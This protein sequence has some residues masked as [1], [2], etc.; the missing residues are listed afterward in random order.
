MHKAR[1]EGAAEY[2]TDLTFHGDGVTFCVRT[3]AKRT[4]ELPYV[5]IQIAKENLAIGRRREPNTTKHAE[6][7]PLYLCSH[8]PERVTRVTEDL[9]FFTEI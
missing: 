3:H 7:E 9:C 4:R 6:L 2:V 8:S 5:I 1:R